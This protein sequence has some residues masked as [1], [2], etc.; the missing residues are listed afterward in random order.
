MFK[1]DIHTHILPENLNEVSRRFSDSRFLQIDLL[2]D[3]SAMLKK[4]GKAFRNVDCNCWNYKIRI[5]ESDKIHVDIQVLSTIPV[6]FSYWA[7]DNDCLTLSQFLNDH[8]AEICREEPHRFIGLGTIPMQNT[9]MA[10]SE[11]DRCINELNLRGIEIGSNINGENLS[12][13]KFH[14]VFEHAE[15]LGCS[16]FIHPWEMMGE[17]NMKKYWL[18]WLVGMPAETSRAI[19]SIIFG[20]VLDKYPNLKIAFA[21]GGGAVPFTIGRIDH[22]YNMRPDLCAI[23]NNKLPS[24]Y[25]K[26]F[27]VDS[28][29]H[30]QKAL[31]YL[32]DIMGPEQVALGSDYP[33]LLGEQHP[34][35]LIEEMNYSNSIKQR[36][37]AGT[38]IEWLGLNESEYIRN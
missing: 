12:A 7:E 18:P 14:S 29:V 2:D 5:E 26:H 35:K 24:S 23:N 38:A 25:L 13:E 9:E 16:I 10:I 27:Y 21:H 28:L 31:S 17:E 32:I 8:I 1:I 30:D 37:L 4:D 22:G 33:F 19:C 20:G 15:K 34:G 11:M 36:M 6:L 3:R